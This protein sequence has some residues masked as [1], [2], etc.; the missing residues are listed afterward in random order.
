MDLWCEIEDRPLQIL[1]TNLLTKPLINNSEDIRFGDI[2]C[3]LLE[4]PLVSSRFLL[5]AYLV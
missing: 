2:T 1:S 4:N 5:L 3:I